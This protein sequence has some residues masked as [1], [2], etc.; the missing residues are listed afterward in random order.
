MP[1]W[2][3]NK[4]E[5]EVWKNFENMLFSEQRRVDRV[6]RFHNFPEYE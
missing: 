2:Q 4:E 6:S 3:Q 5:E 1:L